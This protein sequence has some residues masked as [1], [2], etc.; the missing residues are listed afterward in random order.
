VQGQL[1]IQNASVITDIVK[2]A[3]EASMGAMLGQD[4]EG[5]EKKP[6]AKKEE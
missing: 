2:Q 5:G 3:V 4:E 6:A 1:Q